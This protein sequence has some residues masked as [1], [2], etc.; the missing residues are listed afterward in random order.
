MEHVEGLVG[1]G[2]EQREQ[3]IVGPQS[4]QRRP[5]SRGER[6]SPG[7]EG[8]RLPLLI[9]SLVVGGCTADSNLWRGPKLCACESV[10]PTL[11]ISDGVN[12][13]LEEIELRVVALLG[14]GRP[15][16]QRDRLAGRGDLRRRTPRRRSRTSRRPASAPVGSR[17]T[18]VAQDTRSQHRNRELA[19]ERLARR[20]AGALKV[21]RPRPRRGRRGRRRSGGWRASAAARR[22]QARA[23]AAGPAT[24]GAAAAA[25]ERAARPQR[26]ASAT[27]SRHGRATS[28][29]PIGRPSGEV[30][31][32]H[33]GGRPAGE[34]VGRGEAGGVDS[35][36]RVHVAVAA[37]GLGED[38]AEDEVVALA[39]RRASRAR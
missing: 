25:A 38:G 37:G 7:R 35:P 39:T 10:M 22:D 2:A 27:S 30:P 28:W 6:G 12:V 11:P 17:V 16:R 34:A 8:L 3:L 26:G 9:S 23:A 36:G 19:L 29:T 31:A 4:Q 13:P 20:L 1:A 18:A 15:A 5:R 24:S 33:G 21:A 14:A 32:R